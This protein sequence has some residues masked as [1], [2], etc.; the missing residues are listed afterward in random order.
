MWRQKRSE[1]GKIKQMLHYEAANNQ[2][3]TEE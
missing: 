1:N 2:P 3:I